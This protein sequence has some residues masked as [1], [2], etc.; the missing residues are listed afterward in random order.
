[1][2][3]QPARGVG[4]GECIDIYR[5]AAHYRFVIRSFSDAETENV[6]RQESSK[7]FQAIHKAAL[8][9]LVQLDAAASLL[10]LAVIPGNRLE[11]LQGDREGQYSIRI[12]DQYRV[13]FT[14]E[15]K[16]AFD[17]AIVDYH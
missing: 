7:K 2:R 4:S 8:R 16:D 5:L 1:M 3:C 17:V 6:Y 9:R 10:Q 15:G 13:C 14:W 11:K 12:N